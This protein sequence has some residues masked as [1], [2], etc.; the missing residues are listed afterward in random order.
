MLRATPNLYTF[1]PADGNEV[2]VLGSTIP[3]VCFLLSAVVAGVNI[4]MSVFGAD[5]LFVFAS[6][7]G[8][9]ALIRYM[10]VS[11]FPC[12]Y[13]CVWVCTWVHICKHAVLTHASLSGIS[14]DLWGICVCVKES[15]RSCGDCVESPGYAHSGSF[16]CGEEFPGCVCLC[17]CVYS[18]CLSFF[19]SPSSPPSL[20]PLP[21]SLV[22]P[23]L[24]LP[25]FFSW[26]DGRCSQVRTWYLMWRTPMRSW[27]ER[28][29]KFPSALRQPN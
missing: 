15:P 23:F 20:P 4:F 17:V 1:R 6:M 26:T 27:S 22:S 25:F 12:V 29:L 7:Y 3:A 19:R 9:V 21:F 5:M 2:P 8:C 28:V 11:L 14:A 24:P 16:L 18:F 13:G 10:C